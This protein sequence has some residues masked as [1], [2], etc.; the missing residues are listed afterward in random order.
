MLLTRVKERRQG[1]RS[2]LQ[3]AQWVS[4]QCVSVTLCG[5][6][7]GT[8]NTWECGGQVQ[9]ISCPELPAQGRDSGLCDAP[10]LKKKKKTLV[11]PQPQ[12]C[13]SELLS[14]NPCKPYLDLLHGQGLTN[15]QRSSSLCVWQ[16]SCVCLAA[17]CGSQTLVNLGILQEPA[18]KQFLRLSLTH[19]L[20]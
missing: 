7:L 15:S 5:A 9:G 20:V 18:N 1:A 3:V 2:R 8:A 16:W 11:W 12:P 10:L 14:T 17:E 4:L 6:A 13:K 19:C